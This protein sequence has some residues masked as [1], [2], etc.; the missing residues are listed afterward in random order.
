MPAREQ[1]VVEMRGS[2]HNSTADRKDA[3][4][5]NAERVMRDGRS[6]AEQDE[7]CNRAEHNARIA[8]PRESGT[9]GHYTQGY[10]DDQHLHVQVPGRKWQ[11]DR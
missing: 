10:H 2:Q 4:S 6:D 7:T 9:D 11:Q 5:H 1:A 3:V 8:V